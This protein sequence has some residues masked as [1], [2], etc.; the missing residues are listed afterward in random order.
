MVV[1]GTPAEEDAGAKIDFIEQGAFC[2]IDLS[3]MAHPA[4]SCDFRSRKLALT[5]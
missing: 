3:M 1:Y 2:D 4:P 5:E